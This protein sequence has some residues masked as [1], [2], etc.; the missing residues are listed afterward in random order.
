ML[1]TGSMRR[2][3]KRNPGHQKEARRVRLSTKDDRR[4]WA[5]F[6]G[7]GATGTG[8]DPTG[9]SLDAC[10][11]DVLYELEL[12]DMCEKGPSTGEN[13]ASQRW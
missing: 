11:E 12:E 8:A 7:G 3:G 1:P 4:D 6:A 13:L 2:C 5:M 10:A 9:D